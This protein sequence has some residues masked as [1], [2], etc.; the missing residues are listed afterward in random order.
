[1]IPVNTVK[2]FIQNNLGINPDDYVI[3]TTSQ[4]FPQSWDTPMPA[5]KPPLKTTRNDP[6]T[7]RLSAALGTQDEVDYDELSQTVVLKSKL[8]YTMKVNG[9][10]KKFTKPFNR[11]IFQKGTSYVV[12]IYNGVFAELLSLNWGAISANNG[13]MSQIKA[14]YAAFYGTSE[15]DSEQANLINYMATSE[16]VLKYKPL[17]MT[18]DEITVGYAIHDTENGVRIEIE[19][20][21]NGEIVNPERI[22]TQMYPTKPIQGLPN[23][24]QNRGAGAA[25]SQRQSFELSSDLNVRGVEHVM[26]SGTYNFK[27]VV[28]LKDSNGNNVYKEHNQVI[29]LSRELPAYNYFNL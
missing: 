12:H 15:G 8:T 7:E 29:D 5:S 11:F 9:V 23:T 17:T 27:T 1:M 20:R 4:W 6:D 10:R 24:A 21:L 26:S 25:F 18:S 16:L 3:D 13:L 19:T 22:F 28:T 2:Q 14:G